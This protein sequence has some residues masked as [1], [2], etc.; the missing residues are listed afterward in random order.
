M[1]TI[2]V[3]GFAS[4]GKGVVCTKLAQR[5]GIVHFDTG[6]IY[7][8]IAVHVI[9]SNI[10]PKD[11]DAVVE[12]LKNIQVTLN[13]HNGEQ[14]TILNGDDISNRIR[15][16]SVSNVCSTI[17]PYPEVREFVLSIQSNSLPRVHLMPTLQFESQTTLKSPCIPICK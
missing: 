12:S 1:L 3:D 9:D 10:N 15:S 8:L 13:H 17:S 14:I 11:H 7:R 16:S 6:A 2:A 4:T 5:L